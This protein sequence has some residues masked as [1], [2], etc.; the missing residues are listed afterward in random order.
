MFR[1]GEDMEST[2][3][4]KATDELRYALEVLE[5]YSHLGLDDEY[6]KRLRQILERRIGR[7]EETESCSP[8][9]PVRFPVLTC[10]SE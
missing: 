7:V 5:E 8:A 10:E 3:Q 6:A 1:S 2:I 9:H 4:S